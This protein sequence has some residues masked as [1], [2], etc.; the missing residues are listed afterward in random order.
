MPHDLSGHRPLLKPIDR[1]RQGF[2]PVPE[3]QAPGSVIC[4][5]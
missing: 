2:L 3:E 4:D 5:F 1:R